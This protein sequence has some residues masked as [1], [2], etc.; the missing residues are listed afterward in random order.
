MR[1]YVAEL[2]FHLNQLCS[3]VNIKVVG[4][5]NKP[6]YT[7]FLVDTNANVRTV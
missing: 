6:I 2:Y 5:D 3:E 4:M 7:P 1:C